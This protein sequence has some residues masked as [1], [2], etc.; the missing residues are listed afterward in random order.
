M[1][2]ASEVPNECSLY[3]GIVKHLIEWLK[4][5][6]GEAELDARCRLLPPNHDI[7]LFMKGISNLNRVTGREHDQI[8]R[9]LLGIIIYVKLPGGFSAGVL[10]FVYSAQYPL[11]TTQTIDHL[12][13]ARMRFHR[14]KSIF[15][16]LGIREDFHLPKL[17]GCEHYV[18]NITNFGTTDNYNTEY[19][20]R[21]HIDLAKDAYRST[22]RKDEFSQMPLWLERKEK[23]QR[24]DKFI[25]KLHPLCVNVSD[26]ICEAC[27]MSEPV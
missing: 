27:S 10:D 1:P 6:C 23:I 5:A 12:E 25:D 26:A 15:V 11:H 2:S 20:E 24:H 17:H 16:D 3:R 7:R 18:P 9:F 4:E 19:T 8:C 13:D 21:L 14:N 22:N